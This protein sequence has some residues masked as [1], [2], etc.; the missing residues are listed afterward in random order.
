MSNIKK[1]YDTIQ[2][3]G[4]YSAQQL[5]YHQPTIRNK[6]LQ[7]IDSALQDGQQVLDV[8][9]GTGLI[10]NLF[11]QK[12]PNSQFTAVDFANSIDHAKQVAG[13]LNVQ[14]VNFIKTDFL[15]FNSNSQFDVVICQG[16]LHHIPD[17][18]A[19]ARKIQNLVRPSGT[20]LLGVYHPLGKLAKNWFSIN[21]RNNVL[22]RDQEQ[23]PYEAAYTAKQVL[24]LF[25]EYKIATA[26]PGGKINTLIQ[27]QAL[28]N[29][30]NGGL[31][32][33]TLERK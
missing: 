14:N 21:Y 18:Q 6:Y 20:I 3:P 28:F 29:Y 16:V 9:C 23:N 7:A 8:G 11:A 25:P 27:L 30:R 1:F 13:E 31:V 4:N 12:Y 2:F 15:E 24:E 10:S 26:Y 17:Y 19:A 33:Y 5:Q 22:F 32:L